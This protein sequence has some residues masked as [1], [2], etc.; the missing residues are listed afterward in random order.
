MTATV[1]APGRPLAPT[2]DPGTLQYA[3][4]CSVAEMD[5]DD[6]GAWRAAHHVAWRWWV[7]RC[8]AAVPDRTVLIDVLVVSERSMVSFIDDATSALAAY[9]DEQRTDLARAARGTPCD[10][11]TRARG[12]PVNRPRAEAKLGYGLTGPHVAAIVWTENASA[13]PHLE[14][15]AGRL[16]RVGG[17]TRRL[18]LVASASALWLWMP[19]RSCRRSR[20]SAPCSTT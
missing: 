12:A 20:T 7:E 9:I 4:I 3:G 10:G 19:L 1:Q 13:T 18:T 8:V 15:A 11:S 14:A 2:V 6:L 17:A 5:A 16:M